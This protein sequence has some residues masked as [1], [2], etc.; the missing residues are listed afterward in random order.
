MCNGIQNLKKFIDLLEFQKACAS[1]TLK[2][3]FC[4][5]LSYYTLTWLYEGTMKIASIELSLFRLYVHQSTNQLGYI[6]L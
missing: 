6:R 4:K 5:M 1:S 3:K 2:Y